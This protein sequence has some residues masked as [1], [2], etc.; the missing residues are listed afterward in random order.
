MRAV[1]VCLGG[2]CQRRTSERFE[3]NSGYK[4]A[5]VVEITV[6]RQLPR[7]AKSLSPLD[8]PSLWRRR[9]RM[10]DEFIDWVVVNEVKSVIWFYLICWGRQDSTSI[11]VSLHTFRRSQSNHQRSMPQ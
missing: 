7:L 9:V 5:D 8:A 2:R 10:D 4:P 1:Y 3:L 11:S 6:A